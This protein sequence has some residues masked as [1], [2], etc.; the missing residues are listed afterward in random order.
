MSGALINSSF[1]TREYLEEAIKSKTIT[2]IALEADVAKRTVHSYLS[3]FGLS[4]NV[5]DREYETLDGQVKRLTVEA[6]RVENHLQR[7]VLEIELL[8]M[9]RDIVDTEDMRR[10]SELA[11]KCGRRVDAK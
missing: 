9:K 5:F 3:R 4:A 7:L 11:R 10:I 1:L 8:K 6:T 2:E